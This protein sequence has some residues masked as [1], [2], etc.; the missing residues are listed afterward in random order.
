VLGFVTLVWSADRF[1]EGAAATARNFGVAP[2][3]IGLTIVGF[4]TSA[5]E[6]LV[7]SV[8]SFRGAEGLSIGNAI[9]SN[10]T[11]ATC[12]LGIAALVAPIA[13]HRVI[14]ARELPLL[15]LVI[16]LASAL[17]IDGNLSRLDG[18]LLL[19]GL[20]VLLGFIVWNG[21]RDRRAAMESPPPELDSEI[22]KSM[23]T[24]VAITWVVVGLLALLA[25]AEVVVWGSQ[26]LATM[27]GVPD[28][29]VGLTIVALGTS[30]PE[31]AATVISALKKEH[32]IAFGNI[33][34]SNMFNTLG[35][36]GLPGV[37]APGDVEPTV[38]S[39][40]YP[41]MIGVTVLLFLLSWKFGAKIGTLGRVSGA[42][43]V[44][45]YVAYIGTVIVQSMV[46]GGA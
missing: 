4:G 35:V 45:V 23:S 41:T 26:S 1:V 39:R 38:L 43:L 33:I 20:A 34:G 24:K 32:D 29:V 30:L 9:G 3:I 37:I 2:L 36:L 17:L 22:P 11:N 31:L 8:A 46:D 5:P 27:F 7:S 14:V 10:I 19:T 25:S 40:D 15:L 42:T 6:L 13:V 12:V 28:L 44:L 18:A 16:V 21:I